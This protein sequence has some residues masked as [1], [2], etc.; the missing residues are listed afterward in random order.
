MLWEYWDLIFTE[1]QKSYKISIFIQKV[2]IWFEMSALNLSG[3][4][5]GQEHQL[6]CLTLWWGCSHCLYMSLS[7]CRC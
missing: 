6:Q 2:Y 4:Y 3:E 5:V 1:G 7:C